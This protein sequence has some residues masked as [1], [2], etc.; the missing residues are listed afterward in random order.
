MDRK[1]VYKIDSDGHDLYR[2]DEVKLDGNGRE[3]ELIVAGLRALRAQIALR[4]ITDERPSANGGLYSG[5]GTQRP[6][7]SGVPMADEVDKLFAEIGK[8]NFIEETSEAS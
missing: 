3:A 7:G 8:P 1:D 6:R 5:G 4:D 2:R